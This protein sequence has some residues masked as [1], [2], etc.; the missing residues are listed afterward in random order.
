MDRTYFKH[1]L[2]LVLES[3]LWT[4]NLNQA[5]SI[6]LCYKIGPNQHLFNLIPHSRWADVSLHGSINKYK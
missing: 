5:E 4:R 1:K 6:C 3:H 2:Q